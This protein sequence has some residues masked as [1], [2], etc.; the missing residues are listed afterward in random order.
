MPTDQYPLTDIL[1]ALPLLG[2]AGAIL[3][4]CAGLLG[5]LAYCIMLHCWRRK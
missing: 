4:S 2:R 3:I 5:G 1:H